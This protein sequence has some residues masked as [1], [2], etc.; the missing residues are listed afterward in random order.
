M[1]W[2]ELREYLD[3][4]E[5]MGEL[6]RV[7]VEVDPVLEIAEI[8]ARHGRSPSGGK[9][10]L[11]ERVKGSRFPVLTNL[12][13][14][15][16]RLCAALQVEG[17]SVLTR[18]VS[19][20]LQQIS[21]DSVPAACAALADSPE[22]ARFLPKPVA[23]G[24]CQEVVEPLVDLAQ[25][26]FLKSWPGDS[27]PGNDGRFI[28][29]PLVFTR[30]PQTGAA[31]CGIYLVQVFSGTSVGIRW[32]PRSG[33][34][35]HWRKYVVCGERMP[36]AV[37]LGGDPALT[38]AAAAPLPDALD[39]A[40]FAGFLR[41]KAVEMVRCRTSGIMVP[42]GAELVIEGEIDPTETR[43][44]G[45]FGNH[46]GFYS[47]PQELPVMRVTCVTRRSA[48]IFQ[49]TVIG[50]P[51]MEDCYLAKGVERL[52]VP[53]ARLELPEIVDVSLPL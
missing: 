8:T 18:R 34:A 52:M 5:R 43:S 11:F 44:G 17:L 3:E 15:Y 51:P 39:E 32:L 30:D 29:L 12:F 45:V 47:S 35:Q 16:G 46:T 1:A 38:V 21:A 27:L 19:E 48:P 25:Y 14:S 9:A 2:Q 10:L 31:N 7:G 24:A 40:H 42:A 49:A 53:F 6:R 23:R 41:G 28:T 37:V 4:L 26:P 22:F 13:G 50:P 36:V 20:L 33:G